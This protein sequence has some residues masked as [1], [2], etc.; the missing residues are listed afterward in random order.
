MAQLH[1]TSYN[2]AQIRASDHR[3]VYATFTTE[4][5]DIDHAKEE[6]LRQMLSADIVRR[7]VKIAKNDRRPPPIPVANRLDEGA[8]DKSF[9]ELTLTTGP[10]Q[11]AVLNGED[12]SVFKT[13]GNKASAKRE[14]GSCRP[15][16]MLILM[17]FDSHSSPAPCKAF[18]QCEPQR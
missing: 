4:V 18:E 2:I 3:P 12:T 15:M 16:P 10:S 14:L 7:E 5:H 17:I 11:N 6:S 13:K 9:K 8:P 1:Q